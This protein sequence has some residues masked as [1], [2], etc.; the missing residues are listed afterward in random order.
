MI[1]TFHPV[2]QGAFYTE[3]HKV[4]D[5]EFNI[6]YDCGSG[7]GD[8]ANNII[9]NEID[10]T[11]K[12][13][14]PIDA[15]FISHLH[16]DHVNGL[17]HLLT[18]CKVKKLF[19]PLL[20]KQEEVD[21]LIQYS[22]SGEYDQ[23]IIS[24][25]SDPRSIERDHEGLNIISVAISEPNSDNEKQ[26]ILIN[27]IVDTLVFNKSIKISTDSDWIYLPFNLKYST[28]SSILQKAIK[29]LE[30]SENVN[31]NDINSFCEK[32]KVKEFREIVK[33]TYKDIEGGLNANS[34]TLYSGPDIKSKEYCI[35]SLI[36]CTHLCMYLPFRRSYYINK[37]VGCIYFGDFNAKTPDNWQAFIKYYSLYWDSFVG[38]VQIP[39]HGS[40]HN[41]NPE[42]NRKRKFSVI[43]AGSISQYHH[44]HYETIQEIQMLDGFPLLVTELHGSFVMFKIDDMTQIEIEEKCSK[45]NL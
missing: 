43:S 45:F 41:Y 15:V 36:S 18:H 22:Q 9:I 26:S 42:I 5:K 24:L 39:H 8:A 7:T 10:A 13:K 23:F 33:K 21:I 17:E 11:F 28:R 16:Y 38:T 6:V 25:I 34:M 14:A 4:G 3:R 27:D 40:K 37:R 30:S 19:L 35:S 12:M 31:F 1:R 44:P 20:T 2:G 29:D 32:W